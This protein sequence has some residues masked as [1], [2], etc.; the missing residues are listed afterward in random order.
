M[1]MVNSE[2]KY[3]IKKFAMFCLVIV[4]LSLLLFDSVLKN[5]YLQV[6]PLQLSLIAV[7]TFLSHLRLMRTAGQNIRKFST[8]FLS[9]MSLKLLVYMVFIIICLVIDR[10]RA[11]TFVVTFLILYI[12]FTIFE[13]IEISDFLKKNQKSSN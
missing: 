5:H 2:L 13:V 8:T 11:V 1:N 4:G 6:Y 10:T 3:F 9:T 12:C 7:M